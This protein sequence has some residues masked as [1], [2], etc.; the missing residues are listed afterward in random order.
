M[1]LPLVQ[2]IK[3]AEITT[4]AALEAEI[5]PLRLSST[6]FLLLVTLDELGEATAAELS[7]AIRVFPQSMTTLLK[8][9][10]DR[11]WLQRRVDVANK[12][13]MLIRLGPKGKAILQQARE[14]AKVVEQRLT[15][16]LGSHSADALR[17][18]LTT[19]VGG[20]GAISDG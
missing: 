12:R 20:G 6:Q 8:N 9:L 5:R 1:P 4:R 3:L 15:E 19:I 17:K 11:Q 10:D 2:L 14:R 16:E 13:R 7:R 18:N